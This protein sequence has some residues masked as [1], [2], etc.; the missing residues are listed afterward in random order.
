MAVKDLISSSYYYFYS[1]LKSYATCDLILLQAVDRLKGEYGA[2]GCGVLSDQ[3]RIDSNVSSSGLRRLIIGYFWESSLLLLVS[4]TI[5]NHDYPC[6]LFLL[7][8][9]DW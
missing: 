1:S 6:A 2:H 4:S 9:G 3:E 5:S 8:Q 7:W